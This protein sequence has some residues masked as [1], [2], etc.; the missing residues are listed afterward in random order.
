MT[1]TLTRLWAAI[2]LAV[3][4][5]AGGGEALAQSTPDQIPGIMSAYPNRNTN[6][7]TPWI[8][9]ID[10]WDALTSHKLD[11]N[12]AGGLSL[13]ANPSITT[14][15]TDGEFLNLQNSP[16]TGLT[17]YRSNH[18]ATS[19][20]LWSLARIS[21]DAEAGATTTEMDAL[22][23][24][25][26]DNIPNG[27]VTGNVVGARFVGIVGA[28]SGNLWF[29][30]PG[31]NDTYYGITKRAVL[32]G[33]EHDF[34]GSDGDTIWEGEGFL[35]NGPAAPSAVSSGS[36]GINGGPSVYT[37]NG[38]TCMTQP[39]V[40]VTWTGGVLTVNSVA[41]V[42]VCTT[43]PTNPA[44]ITYA[45]GPATGWTGATVNYTTF[46]QG[47]TAIQIG[48]AAGQT[49]QWANAFVV[50]QGAMVAG[51]AA[52]T[53]GAYSTGAG[54][55]SPPIYFGIVDSVGVGHY[56]EFYANPQSTNSVFFMQ[57]RHLA[58]Y[59]EF[60]MQ[61]TGGS[62]FI[63]ALGTDTNVSLGLNAQG[64]G[65]IN[66]HQGVWWG[67]TQT[68]PNLFSPPGP[69]MVAGNSGGGVYTDNCGGVSPPTPA[70]VTTS[71]T[72]VNMFGFNAITLAS[73]YDAQSFTNGYTVYISGAPIAG[74]NVTIAN[75]Y[76]LY[77]AGGAVSFP[78]ISLRA[79]ATSGSGGVEMCVITGTGV[80]YAKSGC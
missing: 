60:G 76:A 73:T 7:G 35:A 8:P 57:D 25:V 58:N 48:Q 46:I 15:T 23:M 36:G 31:Y 69:S 44:S 65:S 19:Y 5:L 14:P 42:G 41:T 61:D 10:Q 34:N 68:V 79:I 32:V 71:F 72:G 74:T 38:G 1:M 26:L 29:A 13:I 9:T 45:S 37:V 43:W 53:L 63:S 39:Q 50:N 6:G 17:I 64:N 28:T 20:N 18:P 56:D 27:G 3:T 33:I 11:Y 30:N 24:F 80:V 4:L 66:E 22:A 78:T 49:N 77:V 59:L 40:N 55:A 2:L 51:D 75:L 12:P 62:P 21:L 67:R 47:G 54:S 52:I 16:L 70:C